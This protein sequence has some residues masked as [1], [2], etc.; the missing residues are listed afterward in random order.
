LHYNLK[1][2]LLE[3]LTGFRKEIV[4]LDGR[5]IVVEPQPGSVVAPGSV[6][7]IQGEGMPIRKSWSSSSFGDLHIHYDVVIPRTLTAEQKQVLHST[8]P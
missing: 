7:V 4:H 1:V 5:V 6:Y 3:A 8:L 2:T